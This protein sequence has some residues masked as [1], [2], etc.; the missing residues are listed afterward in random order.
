MRF[1]VILIAVFIGC[2]FAAELPPLKISSASSGTLKR[3]KRQ[4]GGFGGFG[5]GFGGFGG[6]EFYTF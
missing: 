4:F 6:K 1:L 2:I 5:G 3:E